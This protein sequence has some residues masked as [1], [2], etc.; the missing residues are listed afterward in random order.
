MRPLVKL[1]AALG[2]FVAAVAAVLFIGA[3]TFLP[4]LVEG[5]VARN[6]QGNLGLT[7]TP[8]VD[9]TAD[10][11]H[12]MLAGRFDSGEVTLEEP[13]FAGVRPERVRVEL[14]GFNVAL[15]ESLGDRSLRTRGPLSGEI[16][17]VLLEDELER[18]AGTGVESFPV[19]GIGVSGGDLAVE[20]ST[21]VL[22]VE[23][24]ISVRGPVGVEDGEIVFEPDEASAFDTALP[25]NVTGQILSGTR[26]GYPI[27]D[28]P[29][30]GEITGIETGE[31]TLSLEGSVR[32]LPVS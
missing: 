25:R 22:G 2:I 16:K 4:V 28:L 13:E 18:I 11:A 23:V 20:S 21:Q 3:Y 19:R 17:V 29:F 12:E 9:L 24:P 14:D 7:Q 6:L 10:P 31:G 26:F 8:E 5:V 15:E 27:E 30:D 32:D 1:V